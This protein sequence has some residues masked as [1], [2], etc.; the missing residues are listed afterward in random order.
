M[1]TA[2]I[3]LTITQFNAAPTPCV[4]SR[5]IIQPGGGGNR[6]KYKNPGDPADFTII[7]MKKGQASLD[8]AFNIPGFTPVPANPVSFAGANA[9]ANFPSQT[10][11]GSTATV[12][13]VF[14]NAGNGTNNPSWKYSIQLTNPQGVPGFIDPEIQNEN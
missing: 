12:T 7:A 5:P 13:N 2:T 1:P 6:V 9:S 8:I 3:T 14:A 11:S 10:V 4:I